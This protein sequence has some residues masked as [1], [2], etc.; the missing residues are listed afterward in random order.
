MDTPKITV[1]SPSKRAAEGLHSG[2]G[3]VD[4]AV[5]QPAATPALPSGWA[6]FGDDNGPVV[7]A[8][9][10]GATGAEAPISAGPPAGTSNTV[11]T[12]AGPT[13]AVPATAG[14]EAFGEA[15]VSVNNGNPAPATEHRPNGGGSDSSLPPATASME[16]KPR[17]A[18]RLEVPLVCGVGLIKC[19]HRSCPFILSGT[20]NHTNITPPC[21]TSSTPSLARSVR[22]GCCQ[23]VSRCRP[24]ATL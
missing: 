14:W 22:Q 7:R 17:P 16:E 11:I 2:G 13:V 19:V 6:A 18:P 12:A 4:E 23:M 21:R 3:Q 10:G 9:P 8:T 24:L 20:T 1:T 5:A 15:S